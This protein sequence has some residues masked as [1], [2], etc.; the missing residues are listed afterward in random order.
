[1]KYDQ[2]KC[3]VCARKLKAIHHVNIKHKRYMHINM[4]LCKCIDDKNIKVNPYNIE[5]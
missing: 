3:S 5:N 2:N 1:M 4:H